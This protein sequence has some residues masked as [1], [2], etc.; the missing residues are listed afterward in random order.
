MC[1]E[2]RGCWFV[3]C[4]FLSVGPSGSTTMLTKQPTMKAGCAMQAHLQLQGTDIPVVIHKGDD[5]RRVARRVLQERQLPRRLE[6]QVLCALAGA[7]EEVMQHHVTAIVDAVFSAGPS[8]E[9][10]DPPVAAAAHPRLDTKSLVRVGTD[11]HL[12]AAA[13]E[14][15]TEL[16]AA[17]AG[18]ASDQRGWLTA[19]QDRQSSE[20]CA[21]AAR[22]ARL[23]KAQADALTQDL[24]EKHR[25]ELVDE[26]ARWQSDINLF[27]L[28][29]RSE[30]AALVGRLASTE[31]PVDTGSSSSAGAARLSRARA[32]PA[33]SPAKA[34]G[35][36]KSSVPTGAGWPP[37]PTAVQK[38][39]R[40]F[41]TLRASRGESPTVLDES[42][43]ALVALQNGSPRTISPASSP[44]RSRSVSTSGSSCSE[45]SSQSASHR[46]LPDSGKG[47]PSPG[48]GDAQQSPVDPP[49][50]PAQVPAPV[51]DS[52]PEAKTPQQ[53][54]VELYQGALT[55]AYADDPGKA[56]MQRARNLQ[57]LL[58][59]WP[60]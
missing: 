35:G 4:P 23:D 12:R 11:A 1:H 53:I 59:T 55:F 8:A 57:V 29:Q 28:Q 51:R 9:T 33:S 20:M 31:P 22:A 24:V 38:G 21:L 16:A 13:A 48:P 42:H 34:A 60:P 37:A 5:L 10:D 36:R 7:M 44:P 50:T 47:T 39:M 32:A 26:A 40:L 43:L 54:T 41:V 18:V 19:L 25:A 45:T 58:V 46:E 30:Y 49:D 2:Q 14:A 17:M 3:A 52:S 6:P 56:Q 15:E 27:L